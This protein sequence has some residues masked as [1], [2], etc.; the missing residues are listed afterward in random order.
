MD[1][2]KSYN[3]FIKLT[4]IIYGAYLLKREYEKILISQ[5]PKNEI[6]K[7]LVISAIIIVIWIFIKKIYNYYCD[8]KHEIK[9][10]DNK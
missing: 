8:Q 3:I 2:N 7:I 5:N 1:N 4:T 10:N 9:Q 6:I